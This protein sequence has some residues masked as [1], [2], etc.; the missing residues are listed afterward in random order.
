MDDL[1][2]LIGQT[3]TKDEIGQFLAEETS[4][5]VW[6]HINSIT[7]SEWASAGQIDLSPSYVASTNAANYAGEKIAQWQGK[8]YAIY[9]TYQADNSDYVEL[10][11]EEQ[12][13]TR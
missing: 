12:A 2:T 5:Q 4:S 7:R 9:R 1:I 13:G 8:R 10:Y 11:L 3:Y 6:A